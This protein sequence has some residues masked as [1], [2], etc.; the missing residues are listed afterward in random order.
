MLWATLKVPA[1]E[2]DRKVAP[3]MSLI[4]VSVRTNSRRPETVC[5]EQ[6]KEGTSSQHE[7]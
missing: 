2:R 5:D 1:R 4:P 3:R 7:L 6:I